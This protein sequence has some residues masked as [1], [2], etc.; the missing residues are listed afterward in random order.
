LTDGHAAARSIG[1]ALGAA[2]AAEDRR[3]GL[4]PFAA[5]RPSLGVARD[6]ASSTKIEAEGSEVRADEAASGLLMCL[7][8]AVGT[9]S[10][11]RRRM[12]SGVRAAPGA[13]NLSA[14]DTGRG[15]ALRQ[16]QAKRCGRHG[17]A[18]RGGVG[19]GTCWHLG[20]SLSREGRDRRGYAGGAAH[21]N[22]G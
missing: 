3:G 13:R 4:P 16:A 20:L 11:P 19:T 5:P 6:G 22:R 15:P 1:L 9:N 2:A 14:D 7:K 18:E 17:G 21:V 8:S 10:I 12:G